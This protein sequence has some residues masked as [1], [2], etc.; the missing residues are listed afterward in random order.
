MG[1]T[2]WAVKAQYIDTS[3]PKWCKDRDATEVALGAEYTINKAT[4]GHL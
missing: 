2:P 4:K 3:K 1:A